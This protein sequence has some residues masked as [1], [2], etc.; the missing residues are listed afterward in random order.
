[1]SSN[2]SSFS[3]ESDLEMLCADVVCHIIM[4]LDRPCDL[5]NFWLA[6]KY[7]FD[8][9]HMDD[10][11]DYCLKHFCFPLSTA[12]L[13]VL[14]SPFSPSFFP[15]VFSVNLLASSNNILTSLEKFSNLESLFI[16]KDFPLKL[17]I[18]NHFP[19]S[20]KNM[21]IRLVDDELQY[22]PKNLLSL[23]LSMSDGLTN[24]S[25]SFRY[26]PN[27]LKELDLGGCG[28]LN[29]LIGIPR[30]IQ[31]LNISFCF[32]LEK[33]DACSPINLPELEW[34][35]CQSVDIPSNVF[36]SLSKEKISKLVIGYSPLILSL[37]EFVSPK[38]LLIISN[39]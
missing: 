1:M 26:L 29:N 16:T 38:K 27:T 20:L 31:K 17:R 14:E 30:S 11:R 7:S 19:S 18:G 24:S 6:W 36:L 10:S 25:N 28:L 35:E 32:S 2:S 34:F 33:E 12:S 5:M 4:F 23:D 21:S 15:K 8:I 13:R 22:L 37:A 39:A 3:E 9:C